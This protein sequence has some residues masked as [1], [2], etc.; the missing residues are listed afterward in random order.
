MVPRH[1]EVV[2][3][4]FITVC[5]ILAA[6]LAPPARAADTVAPH[7]APLPTTAVDPKRLPTGSPARLAAGG[8]AVHV[9]PRGDDAGKGTPESPFRTIR[10]ALRAANAAP[11]TRVVVRAGTY[12]EGEEGDDRALAITAEGTALAAPPRER[13]LVRPASASVRRALA[14]AASGATV[15]GI[16]FEGFDAEGIAIGAEGATLRDIVLADVSI[17]LAKGGDGISVW[18]DP[19]ERGAPV[20]EGLLL[21]RVRVEGADLGI[22]VG[23]GPVKDLAIRDALVRNRAEGTSGSGS[24]GI[25]VERGDNVLLN[26]VEVSGAVADGIDLKASRVAV[27]NAHVHHVGRNGVKLWSGGD[28]VNALVHDCGADASVVLEP[29][30][31]GAAPARYRLVHSMV[32][33]HN[34]SSGGGRAYSL[35]CGYDEPAAKVSL[36]IAGTVFLR[37]PGAVVLSAGTSAT[38]RGSAFLGAK[39]GAVVE[40]AWDGKASRS[41]AASDAPGALGKVGT[42]AGN[43]PFGADPLLSDADA[44]ALAGFRPSARSPLLGAAP[45]AVPP[46]AV[47]LTGRPRPKGAAAI[48]PLEGR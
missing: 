14:I 35:T 45:R 37:N 48:G 24:D 18:P 39:E 30:P 29:G 23:A 36:E 11:G 47:D 44:A 25:A 28:I 15:S 43:L 31:P 21:E 33:F 42:A 10:R 9:D 8:R 16:S 46:V 19:G 22:T 34:R 3:R 40:F 41:I 4:V 20:V 12:L 27:V 26:G 7:P 5:A 13:A 1:H 17:S 6:L 32:A 38:I 2:T